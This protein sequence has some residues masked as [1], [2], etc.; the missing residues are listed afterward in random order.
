MV[1][2]L[3][4]TAAAVVFTAVGSTN[5]PFRFSRA[6]HVRC[7]CWARGISTYPIAPGVELT[8]LAMAEL[9]AIPVPV[10]HGGSLLLPTVWFQVA[11]ARARYPVNTRVVP[12]GPE[13]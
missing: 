6:A 11:F 12:Q 9:L 13:Q 8:A 1:V 10:G 7:A 5:V 3:A 2:G 4:L